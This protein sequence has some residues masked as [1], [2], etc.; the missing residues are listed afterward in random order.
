MYK[1]LRFLKKKKKRR[2]LDVPKFFVIV[3]FSPH[4][5]CLKFVDLEILRSVSFHDISFFWK[6]KPSNMAVGVEP[7][8]R[9]S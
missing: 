4:L 5:W 1:Q 8:N 7:K 9:G 3:S 2:R 6:K